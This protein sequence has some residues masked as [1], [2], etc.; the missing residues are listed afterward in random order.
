MLFRKLFIPGWSYFQMDSYYPNGSYSLSGNA[1]RPG[2]DP[3]TLNDICEGN[4]L[5][6][7]GSNPGDERDELSEGVSY[8]TAVAPLCNPRIEREP[9]GEVEPNGREN[10]SSGLEENL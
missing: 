5:R 7:A 6:A 4:Y 10:S 8:A 2:K 3:A 1:Y 9:M